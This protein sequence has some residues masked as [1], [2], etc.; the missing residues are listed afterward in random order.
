MNIEYILSNSSRNNKKYMVKYFNDIT[1]RINTIHF[2]QQG[3]DDY[4]L[5]NSE[6]AK[7]LYIQR[8]SKDKTDDLRYAGAW[9]M[10]LLWNKKTISASIKQMED[11]YGITIKHVRIKN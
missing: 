11:K 8:H 5:T 7:R 1:G 4:T 3:M 2:G 9:A 6:D 10:N